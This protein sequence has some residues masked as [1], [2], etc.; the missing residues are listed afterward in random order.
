MHHLAR[1]PKVDHAETEMLA[2]IEKLVDRARTP[3]VKR[4]AGDAAK[5]L[6]ILKVCAFVLFGTFLKLIYPLAACQR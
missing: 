6:K 5:L 3:V 1:R 2:T 4:T